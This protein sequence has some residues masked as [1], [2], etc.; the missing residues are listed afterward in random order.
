[1][2]AGR[3]ETGPAYFGG[4]MSLVGSKLTISIVIPCRNERG[5]IGRMLRDVL[6]QEGLPPDAEVL[7]ADGNSNDDSREVVREWAAKDQRVVLVDNPEGT[8]AHGLNRAIA[9][10]TGDVVLRM[11]VHTEYA[12]DYVKSCVTTL[13]RTGADNVGGPARTKAQGYIQ[14]A[15]ALAYH[16]PFSVGGA[17]FHDA[18]YEGPV[19]TVAY[20][21]W[22]RSTLTRLGGFDT[23]LVRNQD[24][25][26]NLRIIRAGGRIWQDE[27]IRSWYHPRARLGAIFRQYRQYGYWKVRVIQKHG[28]PASWR[29]VVPGVFLLSV[30]GVAA[31]A[32]FS[33]VAGLGLATLG[34]SYVGVTLAASAW[35]CRR[36]NHN[37]YLPIMPLVFACYHF[38]YGI[39]FLE[40]LMDFVIAPRNARQSASRAKRDRLTR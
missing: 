36:R 19:D 11:D 21:C 7:V 12:P 14:K 22:W 2:V 24:D 16:S 27:K 35:A 25:E 23:E 33:T 20:G 39:G 3:R 10:A 5:H 37:I 38:G 28:R 40:G 31:G 32:P 29:H 9:R 8:T 26:L 1:V 18:S 6:Q 4:E 15:N 30:V 17:R 13:I 34:G